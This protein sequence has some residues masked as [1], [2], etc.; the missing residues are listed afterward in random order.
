MK[1][2]WRHIGAVY[3]ALALLAPFLTGAAAEAATAK[4]YYLI[5]D[6]TYS[7]MMSEQLYEEVRRLMDEDNAQR[8][9]DLLRQ[10]YGSDK[11][12]EQIHTIVLRVY[13]YN[14]TETGG[15]A[16]ELKPDGAGQSSGITETEDP[17]FDI[18]AG[19]LLNYHGDDKV[20]TIPDGVT[21]ISQGAFYNNNKVEKIVVPSNVTSVADY[22]FYN[23]GRLKSI[24]FAGKSKSLG[25]KMI[26]KCSKLQNIVAPKN[27]NEWKYAAKEGIRTFT[28]DRPTFGQ[29]QVHLLAGDSE[30][31]VLYNAAGIVK[32]KSSAKSVVSVSSA[33][34]I[35]CLKKGKAIIT[36]TDGG[37]VYRLTV[38]VSE[39][40]ENKRI[41]QIIRTTIK[42]GMSTREK[43]KAV[44]DWLIR[45]VKYDYD[46]FLRGKVPKISHTSQGALLRGVAVCDGYSKAMKKILNRLGIPCEI[47]IGRC[48]GAGHAWNM[49]KTDGKWLYVDVTFDDPIVNGKNTNTKPYYMYF[50][51]TARQ[52]R[53]DHV[54]G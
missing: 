1:C 13:T 21:H 39:K 46:S 32:W 51:K 22:A 19:R 25:N 50:L 28:T 38:Y 11:V 35:K 30:K 20:V 4:E 53:K 3:L 43:I 5:L 24:V 45:N 9:V 27:S 17:D 16:P 10:T 6:N 54:W 33:G 41:A 29:G 47:V 14:G 34:K 36:A 44:H 2:V 48:N 7:Y 26:Y 18:L 12:P 31:L 52:M 15:V 37:R 49:V 40:S 42:K 8:I 23:C